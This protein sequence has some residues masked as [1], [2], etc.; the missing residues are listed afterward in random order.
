MTVRLADL[1]IDYHGTTIPYERIYVFTV[2]RREW[3]TVYVMGIEDKRA[4]A[5]GGDDLKRYLLRNIRDAREVLRF[6]ERG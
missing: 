1:S 5:L 3:S 2:K 4:G 6:K